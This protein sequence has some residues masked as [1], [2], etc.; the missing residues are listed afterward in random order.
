MD[1]RK[2]LDEI[3]DETW[4]N[5][6]DEFLS[7]EE[8]IAAKM[9]AIELVGGYEKL[10]EQLAIGVKNGYSIEQQFEILRKLFKELKD[11]ETD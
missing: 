10:E 5:E 4:Y 2:K 3:I 11:A 9:E 6:F 7:K 8:Q 1:I